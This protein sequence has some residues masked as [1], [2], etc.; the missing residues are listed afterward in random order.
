MAPYQNARRITTIGELL[1]DG[2]R[3]LIPPPSL[4][5]FGWLEPDLRLVYWKTPGSRK[6]S[7]VLF[8]DNTVNCDTDFLRPII[9]IAQWERGHDIRTKPHWASVDVQLGYFNDDHQHLQTAIHQF[10]QTL[11]S[12]PFLPFGL[13]AKRQVPHFPYTDRGKLEIFANNGVQSINFMTP[14]LP[15]GDALT[16]QFFLLLAQLETACQPFEQNEWRERYN[17]NLPELSPLQAWDWDGNNP[18]PVS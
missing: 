13:S 12:L 5:D 11:G 17:Y 4:D 7:V 10:H 16:D 6:Q 14:A 8:V 18:Q 15:D 2:P 9:R 3:A 1:I